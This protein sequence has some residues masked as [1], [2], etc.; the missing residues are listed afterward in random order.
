MTD[1]VHNY[2]N[3]A[4]CADLFFTLKSALEVNYRNLFLAPLE[5]DLAGAHVVCMLPRHGGV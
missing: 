3:I 1:K 5:K 4:L 2:T